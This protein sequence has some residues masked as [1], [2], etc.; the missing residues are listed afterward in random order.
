VLIV[1]RLP[2]A[3]LTER[4]EVEVAIERPVLFFAVIFEMTAS[5]ETVSTFEIAHSSSNGEKE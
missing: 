2:V 1:V 5:V 3:G 4:G